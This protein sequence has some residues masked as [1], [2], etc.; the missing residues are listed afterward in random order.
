MKDAE[1]QALQEELDHLR[2]CLSLAEDRG[3]AT[4]EDPDAYRKQID[5][6]EQR[7][8]SARRRVGEGALVLGQNIEQG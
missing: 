1:T 2:V 8:A 4:T 5:K 3:N 7:I 6:F